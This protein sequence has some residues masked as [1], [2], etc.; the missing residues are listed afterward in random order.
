MK[1]VATILVISF[2]DEMVFCLK[3]RIVS[4]SK[5]LAIWLIIVGI[6][7]LS[8]AFI[9]GIIGVVVIG[10]GK[11]MMVRLRWV[12]IFYFFFDEFSILSHLENFKFLGI[13]TSDQIF[14]VFEYLVFI[15]TF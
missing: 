15:V 9:V 5:I 11:K 13:D 1:K 3:K 8:G 10:G 7:I 2:D 14:V 12:R 4:W 6:T